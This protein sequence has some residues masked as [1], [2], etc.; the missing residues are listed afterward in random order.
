MTVSK[1]K[2]LSFTG[3]LFWAKNLFVPDD[4]RGN[5]EWKVK[6]GL[7]EDQLEHFKAANTRVQIRTNESYTDKPVVLLRRPTE[8]LF[9]S[10]KVEFDP[11]SV[12]NP[13]GTPFQEFIGN[14]TKARVE[15][16]LYPT[17]DGSGEY[18]CRLEKVVVLEL[19]GY[20]APEEDNEG[21]PHDHVPSDS[22]PALQKPAF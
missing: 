10:G 7:D 22:E 3:E 21:K 8:K 9:S 15:C 11:P 20:E 17:A 14:E 5:K 1:N 6:V 16:S 2:T 4:Y 18:V 12:V 19:V 13:D